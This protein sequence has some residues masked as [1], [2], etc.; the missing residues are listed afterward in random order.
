MS[1]LSTVVWSGQELGGVQTEP[2][3]PSSRAEP[4]IPP[5]WRLMKS[6]GSPAHKTPPGEIQSVCQLP[7]AT[8]MWVANPG[9]SWLGMC[10]PH[11]T[12]KSAVL[13]KANCITVRQEWGSKTRDPTP[14]KKKKKSLKRL[15]SALMNEHNH[16]KERDWG[17]TEDSNMQ[18]KQR[19]SKCLVMDDDKQHSSWLNVACLDYTSMFKQLRTFKE[20]VTV[21]DTFQIFRAVFLC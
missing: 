11:F 20:K 21:N 12:D 6:Q 5:S 10:W 2:S 15:C 14:V 7:S 8:S 9:T 13:R 18:Y 1:E 3:D 19:S 17:P 4:E 16:G